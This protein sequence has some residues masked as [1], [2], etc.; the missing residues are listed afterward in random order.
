MNGQVNGQLNTYNTDAE[1][2]SSLRQLKRSYSNGCLRLSLSNVKE[3]HQMPG[4]TFDHT[5]V[6][7]QQ[8]SAVPTKLVKGG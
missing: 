4:L 3:K 1:L 8:I 5:C 2:Y 7:R 6:A